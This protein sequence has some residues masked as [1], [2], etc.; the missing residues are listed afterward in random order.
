MA[1]LA[2]V[3]C[4]EPR[5]APGPEPAP[6]QADVT[7]TTPVS[8]SPA[9]L[10]SSRECGEAGDTPTELPP[11]LAGGMTKIGSAT[12]RPGDKK[13]IGTSERK[14]TLLFNGYGEYVADLYK[15]LE[16]ERLWA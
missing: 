16:K 13:F 5:V 9:A 15:G 4:A 7:P 1:A 6:T 3:T 10:P 11:R 2:L 8:P 12:L 14:P